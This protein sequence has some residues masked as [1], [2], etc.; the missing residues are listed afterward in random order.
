[1]QLEP[2]LRH[3][4][5]FH[6]LALPAAAL[7]AASAADENNS[8]TGAVVMHVHLATMRDDVELAPGWASFM[9]ASD[10][11]AQLASTSWRPLVEQVR[12]PA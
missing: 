8:Q 3:P 2:L 12:N 6:M 5:P 7:L 10:A 4:H 1:M 11:F 9:P